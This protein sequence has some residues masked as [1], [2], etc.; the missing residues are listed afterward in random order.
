MLFFYIESYVV[1]FL[2]FR[3]HFCNICTIIYIFLET[4]LSKHNLSFHKI[5]V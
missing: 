3:R 5:N 2:G 4:V 1:D